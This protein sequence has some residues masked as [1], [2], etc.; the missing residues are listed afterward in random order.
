MIDGYSLPD[1]GTET[2][3]GGNSIFNNG[4]YDV[5]NQNTTEVKA[6][7]NW[8]GQ[9]PPNPAFFGGKV[10][11][12]P[13]LTE[14]PPPIAP[15]PSIISISPNAGPLA[16]GTWIKITGTNFATGATV[17]VG[18]NPATDVIVVSETE[19]TAKTPVGTAGAKDV[20]VTN[21]DG[22]SAT[23]PNGFFYGTVSAT[24]D[25]SG[26]GTI[27]AYDA[28]LILQYVVGLI[29]CFP[30]DCPASQAAQRYI[31]GE[32]TIDELDKILQKLG[33]P[34]VFKL[35]GFEN[36]LLQNYPNP[37][38]PETWIPFKL[39]Q[40]ASV[41]IN[42]YDTKGQLIRTISVGNKPAGVYLAKDKAAYWDGRDNAGEKVSSGLYFYT[43][44]AGKFR[45]TRKMVIVK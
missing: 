25:V 18:G 3:P 41:T 15:P 16:G 44:E 14:P 35:L 43:L 8:W 19:I 1:L 17:D 12:T 9:S 36:Q 38:N 21:P 22:Q 27:S 6:E 40:N 13:W 10:D 26:D 31:S 39:A 20:S 37:F 30:A 24:G 23:L 32:I 2:E 33:Y 7:L 42:I 4:N 34:S 45:S 28:A 29:D 11:Y 5:R